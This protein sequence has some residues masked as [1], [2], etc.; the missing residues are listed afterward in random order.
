MNIRTPV[1]VVCWIPNTRGFIDFSNPITT[2]LEEQN[3]SDFIGYNTYIDLILIINEGGKPT[4]IEVKD[5]KTQEDLAVFK[6]LN[7]T[8]E[9]FLFLLLTKAD[10]SLTEDDVKK[11]LYHKIKQFWH[12][13]EYHNT[14]EDSI[15]EAII[16]PVRNSE[17]VRFIIQNKSSLKLILNHLIDNFYTYF[18]NKWGLLEDYRNQ[19]LLIAFQG[20]EVYKKLSK[21][22]ETKFLFKRIFKLKNQLKKQATR[23]KKIKRI[24]SYL[25]RP[26]ELYK[27]LE[28]WDLEFKLNQILGVYH[29]YIPIRD[30]YLSLETT[31]DEKIRQIE[32]LKE[33]F[34]L[35]RE[36]ITREKNAIVEA[37]TILALVLAIFSLLP[38]IPLS[39][40]SMFGFLVFYTLFAILYASLRR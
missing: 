40:F 6:V 26:F 28:L 17:Q 34:M 35:R 38:L 22:L 9:G 3:V 19:N 25:L 7:T 32:R 21:K 2:R 13:D 30:I 15:L 20:L 33:L 31:P 4:Q 5:S 10:P 23:N 16:F 8:K 27:Y 37:I 39:F 36:E 29:Y 11:T 1:L 18:D 14:E 12:S 24:V